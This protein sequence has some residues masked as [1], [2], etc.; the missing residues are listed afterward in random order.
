MYVPKPAQ[1]SDG[2]KTYQ[3]HWKIKKNLHKDIYIYIYIYIWQREKDRR[4]EN[5]AKP[6]DF[7]RRFEKT[8]CA[9]YAQ[10][11]TNA[12]IDLHIWY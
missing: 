11:Q 9:K 12:S 10:K 8:E 4:M 2:P 1:I 7:I 3:G 5:E 6:E